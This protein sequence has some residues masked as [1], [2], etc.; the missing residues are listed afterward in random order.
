MNIREIEQFLPETCSV[1]ASAQH[2]VLVFFYPYRLLL[3]SFLCWVLCSLWYTLLLHYSV[4][5]VWATL[6]SRDGAR[7]FLPLPGTLLPKTAAW[8]ASLDFPKCPL[9]SEVFP[10]HPILNFKP[11]LCATLLSE[12]FF[13]NIHITHL[14][15]YHVIAMGI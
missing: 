7:A 5:P 8:L 11:P 6:L 4:Q 13:S 3:L 15:V 12:I 1:L 9:L 14:F 2:T 10:H